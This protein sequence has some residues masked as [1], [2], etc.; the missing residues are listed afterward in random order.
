MSSKRPFHSH[1][2]EGTDILQL[3]WVVASHPFWQRQ[4][5]NGPKHCELR[6]TNCGV[7]PVADKQR[8][9]TELLVLKATHRRDMMND[10]R[11]KARVTLQVE[12]IPLT[13]YTTPNAVILQ[14]HCPAKES[15]SRKHGTATQDISKENNGTFFPGGE[16]RLTVDAWPIC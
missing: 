11:I 4:L 6:Q 9:F 10:C 13:T 5:P 16:S 15:C 8:L 14:A 7:A 3:C 2:R 12:A 1:Q